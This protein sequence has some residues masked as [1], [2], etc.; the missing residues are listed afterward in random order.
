MPRLTPLVLVI[1]DGFGVSLDTLGNP[2]AEAKKP[3][4]EDLERNFPFTTLQASGVAVGLP[5]GEAGNSEVG[6]LTMGAGR[7]LHHHLPRIIHAIRDGSFFQNPALLQAARHV[8]RH[9]S[10]LHIAG[11]VSSGSVHSYLDHLSALAEFAVREALPD[12]RLHVFTDGKDAP[13]REAASFLASLAA[14]LRREAPAVK[15]ATVVGRFFAMDRDEKWD[16]VQRT[17]ELLT[18]GKGEYISSIPQYLEASYAK[19]ISDDS[20]E[21]AIVMDDPLPVIGEND[22]LIFLNFREDSM[23]ELA[24][25][26]GEEKFDKFPRTRIPNL[27]IVSMT[28][29]ERGVPGVVP[30]FPAPEIAHPLGRVLSDAGLRQLR[31]AESEKYAHVT[32][33]FNGGEE[34]PFAGEDRILIPSIATA[35]F[36]EEPEMR[37][38][39]IAV[40][41]RENIGQYDVIVANFANADMVGHSGNFTAAV[42]AVEALDTALKELMDAIG[43]C[44]GAMLI[45]GDHGNIELKRNMLSGEKRTEHSINPVPFLLVGERFRRAAPR[46]NAEIALRK[47]EIG[48][49]LT[50]VAPTLLELLDIPKP[51]EMT[52][53]SLLAMLT[54]QV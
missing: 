22:A 37:S 48:G 16:R 36:D 32:Y 28:A 41:I 35:H 7:V 21:P 3:V 44:H 54:Q 12:V 29:Y 51:A 52:G 4:W 24:R 34:K 13:P 45:T 39:E 43:A 2:V 15:L 11:L 19:G 8:R 26:F 23:R 40:K 46:T 38:R 27:F 6:H 25:A 30:A 47:K 53:Q 1:L 42:R 20:I 50:D 10:R 31:I 5:W 14:R 49:I 18:G 33:F 17:Y 9:H